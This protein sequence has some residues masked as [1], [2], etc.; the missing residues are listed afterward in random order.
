MSQGKYLVF[1]FE[2]TGVGK[3][4]KN[5]YKLYSHEARPLPRENFPVEL[6][7]S[8]V[9]D[10]AVT[11]TYHTLIQGASRLD[12]WVLENCPNLS[13]K[14]CERDGIPLLEAVRALAD[15]AGPDHK[16]CTLVAHNIQY[17]W[18]D[19]IVR[20]VNEVD[21]NTDDA[22][23]ALSKCKRYCTCVNP[24]TKASGR[25]YFYKKI[26]K[27]IGPKLKDLA[28]SLNVEYDDNSAHD[29]TYDVNVTVQCLLKSS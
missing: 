16:E 15:L 21:A 25:A 12:P 7:A 22:Y 5:N 9:V 17:D 29:A 8:L 18:A 28:S 6:A 27:W 10:G 23:R 26:G 20:T 19:V 11:R 3:D 2:T 4:S 1:D 14:D 13:V 24:T